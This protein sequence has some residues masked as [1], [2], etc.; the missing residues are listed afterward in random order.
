[1]VPVRSW[2]DLC[3]E[4]KAGFC[5]SFSFCRPS[6]SFTKFTKIFVFAK[7]WRFSVK[8]GVSESPF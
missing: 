1:M 2:A 7:I 5:K 8:K 3:Q 6:V 4:V